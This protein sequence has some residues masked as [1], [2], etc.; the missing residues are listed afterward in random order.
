[1]ETLYHAQLE[2]L[3]NQYKQIITSSSVGARL[4]KVQRYFD[5]CDLV[6][7][8][9]RHVRFFDEMSFYMLDCDID[10]SK[11]IDKE[12]WKSSIT[13]QKDI[14]DPYKV[15]RDLIRT[16]LN[17]MQDHLNSHNKS[18]FD[19]E[20]RD[21]VGTALNTINSDAYIDDDILDNAYDSAIDELIH[22]LSKMKEKIDNFKPTKEHYEIVFN[23]FDLPDKDDIDYAERYYRYT[24][25]KEERYINDFDDL[26][27]FRLICFTELADSGF[28]L[29]HQEDTTANSRYKL[30]E[31]VDFS[32]VEDAEKEKFYMKC[33]TLFRKLVDYRDDKYIFN[34]HKVGKYLY[35]YRK[36]MAY[37]H[38]RTFGEVLFNIKRIQE[39]M[40]PEKDVECTEINESGVSYPI[41]IEDISSE[42][43]NYMLRK[44]KFAEIA[45]ILNETI[46]PIVDAT[47]NKANWD[48]VCFAFKLLNI[49]NRTLSREK[50]AKLIVAMCPDLG[51]ASRL[52]SSMEKSGANYTGKYDKYEEL[53]ET[54]NL[55]SNSKQ[56]VDALKSV[57]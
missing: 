13:T 14:T 38:I 10:Y 42:L 15:D 17:Y 25:K 23:S 26:K 20:K 51:D 12:V 4:A 7:E 19:Y 5:T 40:Y 45:K 41:R 16:R 52:N 9:R 24:K 34:P 28:F 33:Y 32:F 31:E 8:F 37:T 46:K 11:W 44:D 43:Q 1:M 22:L 27:E 2:N 47:G 48:Y 35:I 55:K 54:N 21:K 53:L 18:L 30:K 36:D 57:I 29:N 56:Y 3:R 39:D 50:F 49:V 6:D